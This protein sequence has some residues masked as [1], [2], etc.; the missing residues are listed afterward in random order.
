[1]KTILTAIIASLLLPTFGIC[2]DA[3]LKSA[4]AKAAVREYERKL[5]NFDKEFA[6]Q[7]KDLE[8]SYQMKA[9]LV[10]ARLLSNLNEA[11]EEEARKV[12]LEEAN[13]IKGV[14]DETKKAEPLTL[15][16]LTEQAGRKPIKTPKVRI[17]KTAVKFEGNRYVVITNPMPVYYAR[18]YADSLGGHVVRVDSE[19]EEMFC[20][21]LM[22]SRSVGVTWLDACDGLTENDWI[23]W[24]GQK[25]SYFKWGAGEPGNS[26]R[27]EHAVLMDT[28]GYW[29][30]CESDRRLPFIIEWDK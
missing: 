29:N 3:D 25:A 10:R 16:G 6:K 15:N 13:K 17:P 27:G 26:N 4:K 7:L 8:K 1:M 19:G 28:N 22:A 12:N 2:Q 21:D 5:E 18:L 24:N 11:M 30:D 9:E 14:I 23:N 20:R